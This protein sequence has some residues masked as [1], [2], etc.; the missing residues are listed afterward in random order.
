MYILQKWMNMQ[1]LIISTEVK[2]TKQFYEKGAK[3]TLEN[4]FKIRLRCY[5]ILS[6]L[7]KLLTQHVIFKTG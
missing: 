3:F 6:T 2:G 7:S 1:R 4:E 5:K